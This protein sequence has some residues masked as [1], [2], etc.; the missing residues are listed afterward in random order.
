M[1]RPSL[2]EAIPASARHKR[3]GRALAAVLAVA[4]TPTCAL[5]A[6]AGTTINNIA[7]L[8][9]TSVTG[10]VSLKS[11]LVSLRIQE[12]IDVRVDAPVPR[13]SV[14]SGAAEQ[15]LAFTVTNTGNGSEAFELAANVALG[16]DGF[17][18]QLR[19]IWIDTD[20]DGLLD[21]AKDA[22]YRPGQNAPR[23]ASGASVQVWVVCDI[24][25]GLKDET[26]GLV[27]LTA[28]SAS[29][30]GQA[31]S[32]LV[33]KGDDGVDAI[34]GR[35]AATATATAGYRIGTPK[36]Q[37]IKS[38]TVVDVLGGARA[39]PGSIVVY[40][41]EARFGQGPAIRQAVIAD[42]AP[43]GSTYLPGTLRL[44]GQLLTDGADGDAGDV[45]DGAIQVRIGDVTTPVSRIVTFKVR[46]NPIVSASL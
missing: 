18:P 41:L 5:A 6:L 27:S 39:M 34:I 32:L 43:A 22:L 13:V 1:K 2:R 30:Q 35:T 26:L 31:G 8:D 7:S 46:I 19:E 10:P 44:D 16:D 21:R 25:A 23:L 45:S 42:T 14:E 33:G 17:D 37:L 11:N 24:P 15:A 12:I 3:S 29:G 38:Q 4:A 28:S 20:G 36:A 9:Y 40:S